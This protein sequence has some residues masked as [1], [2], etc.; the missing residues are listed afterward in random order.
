M[1]AADTPRVLSCHV[2]RRIAEAVIRESSVFGKRIGR[3]E[4]RAAGMQIC[5]DHLA[6]VVAV[7]APRQIAAWLLAGSGPT[8]SR[9]P[10]CYL[11]ELAA[12]TESEA[13]REPGGVSCPRHGTPDP[14]EAERMT[15]LLA[16]IAAGDRLPRL[17]EAATLRA[18]L[19]E[20]FSIRGSNA[21]VPRIE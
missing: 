14:V 15:E 5:A 10:S 2:C 13:P 16:R 17:D 21:H 9:P 18:A 11:C 8:D 6:V 4:A 12:R 19:I 20:R 3:G 7:T 1:S